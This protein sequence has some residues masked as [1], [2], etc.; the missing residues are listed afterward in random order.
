[1]S[2]FLF[3]N[4][5]IFANFINDM[6]IATT[7][8]N[9]LRFLQNNRRLN[10]ALKRC[11]DALFVMIDF[12]VIVTQSS[13]SQALKDEETLNLESTNQFMKKLAAEQDALKKI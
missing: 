6:I 4:L 10:V 5:L 11:I 3:E 2:S 8:K 9:R 1:M 12:I 13:I 7:R